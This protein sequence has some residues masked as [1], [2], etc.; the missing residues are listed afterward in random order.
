MV[1]PVRVGA[2]TMCCSS[3]SSCSPTA[4]YLKSQTPQELW[5]AKLE[6]PDP[7]KPKDLLDPKDFLDPVPLQAAKAP[8]TGILLDITA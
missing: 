1:A 5:K 2:G 7:L 8:G 4:E 6:L 3:A